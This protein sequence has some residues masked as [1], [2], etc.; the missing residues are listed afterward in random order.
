[1]YSKTIVVYAR[2]SFMGSLKSFITF[3]MCIKGQNQTGFLKTLATRK[4]V[5]SVIVTRCEFCSCSKSHDRIDLCDI[6][7]LEKSSYA[8][9]DIFLW[10][11]NL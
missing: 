2:G 6:R 8:L 4:S 3:L 9:F 11:K 10:F 1:M 5:K 7:G